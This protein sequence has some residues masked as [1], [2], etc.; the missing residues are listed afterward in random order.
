MF[1]HRNTHTPMY[2]HTDL[3]VHPD[4]IAEQGSTM[5]TYKQ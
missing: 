3:E 2:T 4:F 1:I 5:A